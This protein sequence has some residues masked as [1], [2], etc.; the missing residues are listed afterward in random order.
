MTSLGKKRKNALK[1]ISSVASP[2]HLE[3]DKV[4]RGM[5]VLVNG[6]IGV[7][8]FSDQSVTLLISAMKVVITGY[9]MCITVYE[10]KSVEIVGRIGRIDYLYDK[11]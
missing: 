7:A 8:E 5:A 11:N 6:V 3:V 1:S 4:G 9:G 2:F 10:N